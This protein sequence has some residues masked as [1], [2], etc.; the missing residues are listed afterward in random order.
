GF[1]NALWAAKT[2]SV[3]YGKFHP[4]FLT[5]QCDRRENDLDSPIFS[6]TQL[7]LFFV[8]FGVAHLCD[9]CEE[10]SVCD[11]YYSAV[12]AHDIAESRNFNPWHIVYKCREIKKE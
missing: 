7:H 10:K 2:R 8:K 3:K 5:F 4:S 12:A 9:E 1:A 6:M 11:F